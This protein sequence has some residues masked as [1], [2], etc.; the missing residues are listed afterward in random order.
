MDPKN[1][2]VR[3]TVSQSPVKIHKAITESISNGTENNK[4]NFISGI[5]DSLSR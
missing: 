1:N 2:T 5:V 3:I 4:S